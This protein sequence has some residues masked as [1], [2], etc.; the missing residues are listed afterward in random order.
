MYVITIYLDVT[1]ALSIVDVTELGGTLAVGDVRLEDAASTLT[2]TTDNATHGDCNKV[3]L[4]MRISL[5][6]LER[7]VF[8]PRIDNSRT[9]T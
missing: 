8:R 9:K 3:K 7:H 6:T 1:V 4:A 5:Y 2:L